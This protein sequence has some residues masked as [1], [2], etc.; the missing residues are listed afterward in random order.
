MAANS[1][2]LKQLMSRYCDS[3]TEHWRLRQVLKNT[4]AEDRYEAMLSCKGSNDYIP[5]VRSAAAK[6]IET[7]KLMLAGFTS[8]QFYEVMKHEDDDSEIPLHEAAAKGDIDMIMY[9]LSNLSLEHR[10]EILKTATRS[11]NTPAH[12]AALK[13]KPEALKL[14][15]TCVTA[16][17]QKELMKLKSRDGKT[18]KDLITLPDL[19]Y[20]YFSEQAAIWRVEELESAVT[21]HNEEITKQASELSL[22]NQR[23]QQSE[24]KHDAEEMAIAQQAAEL[25]NS[26]QRVQDLELAFQ[27]MTEMQ[28]EMQR[29]TQ[30]SLRE[31]E[32]FNRICFSTTDTGDQEHD[33]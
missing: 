5:A 10:F 25:Q 9:L 28:G 4:S 33:D 20:G 30:R 1:T 13:K 19:T 16:E 11:G 21:K 18:I 32:K 15:L 26:N 7:M 23:I 3:W 6:D 8:Y 31:M 12:W 17:Q 29:E 14:L 27:R 2:E 24:S 22:A